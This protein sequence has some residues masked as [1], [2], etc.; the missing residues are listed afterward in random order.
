MWNSLI[1]GFFPE[2][3]GT[4]YIPDEHLDDFVN[5]K[6]PEKNNR[7]RKII[8]QSQFRFIGKDYD[9]PYEKM[10]DELF[11]NY[12]KKPVHQ[13]KESKQADPQQAAP[14]GNNNKSKD[15]KKK[16]TKKNN[17]KPQPVAPQLAPQIAPQVA[18]QVASQPSTQKT[19]SVPQ[20]KPQISALQNLSDPAKQAKPQE[21]KKH[22]KFPNKSK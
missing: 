19:L 10:R 16:W 13:P 7:K 15:G 2:K 20:R 9:F 5:H 6:R 3:M 12:K 18:L 11:A 1:Q 8:N 17:G 14:Q 4:Y 21:V 22:V